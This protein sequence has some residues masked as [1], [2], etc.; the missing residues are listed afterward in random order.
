VKW[1]EIKGTR[2]SWSNSNDNWGRHG[3]LHL[4]ALHKACKPG[5][6][7]GINCSYFECRIGLVFGGTGPGKEVRTCMS[8]VWAAV[9]E[10]R[11]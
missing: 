10:K 5:A 4:S 6:I 1:K 11:G 2:H 8:F 3:F 9:V 7:S